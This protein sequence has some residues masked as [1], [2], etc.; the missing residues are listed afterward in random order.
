MDTLK[1]GVV[2]A[3]FQ[4]LLKGQVEHILVPAQ[5][6]SDLLVVLLGSS[7]KART[8]EDPFND[9][10][11]QLMI[12]ESLVG[13]LKVGHE[14]PTRF[15]PI[16]DF[17]Y[18]DT[19]VD[20]ITQVQSKVASA[21]KEYRSLDIKLTNVNV[22][23]TLYGAESED[24]KKYHQWF[25]QWDLK[26]SRVSDT[27]LSLNALCQLFETEDVYT[28]IVTEQTRE[29]LSEWLKTDE[30][31]TLQEE[32][33]YVKKYK[34]ATQVGRYAIQFLTVDN[35]VYYKGNILL[36]KRRSQPGKGLWAL[37]GGFLEATETCKDGAVRELLEETRLR[38][39]QEWLVAKDCFDHPRRSTRGRT[40]TN[41][42][43]WK[44]PDG[45]NFPKVRAGSDAARVKWFPLAHI[46]EEMPELLFED[47][48]DIISTLT[49]RL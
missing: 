9:Y 18:A 24:V 46:L 4:P 5:K 42:F 34:A 1:V 17:L 36:V 10:D 35:V 43:L 8:S 28:G 6:N 7:M 13:D 33:A 38:V 48:L 23:V 12:E 15:M 22:E 32:Y 49:K 41:A 16:R 39:R 3:R 11:R 26:V 25:P 44:I 40:L 29:Y 30:G 2:I 21:I 20:W 14:N 45:N 37:P 27:S 19:P 47:H 31:R